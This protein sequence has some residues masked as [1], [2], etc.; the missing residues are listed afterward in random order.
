M[1]LS[2]FPSCS[3]VLEV[4]TDWAR[5]SEEVFEQLHR[6]LWRWLPFAKSVRGFSEGANSGK[7]APVYVFVRVSA[8]DLAITVEVLSGFFSPACGSEADLAGVTFVD[9]G[10]A[11]PALVCVVLIGSVL[12]ETLRF[13]NARANYG[14]LLGGNEQFAVDG[15]RRRRTSRDGQP[16]ETDASLRQTVTS[17]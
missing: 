9:E 11:P 1:N 10:S 14:G 6:R 15:N 7:G 13:G 4:D 12:D 5:A 3:A 8:V 2:F 17:V 16:A